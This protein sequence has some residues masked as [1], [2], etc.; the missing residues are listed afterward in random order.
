MGAA[1]L[2]PLGPL[3]RATCPTCG[4]PFTPPDSPP[5]SSTAAPPGVGE[6]RIVPLPRGK[7]A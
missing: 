4:V 5:Y 6:D 1:A 2:K 7:G 3:L